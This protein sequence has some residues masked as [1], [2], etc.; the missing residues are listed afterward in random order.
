MAIDFEEQEIFDLLLEQGAEPNARAS[1][2]AAGFG[3]HT[4][5]FNAVVNCGWVQPD[6]V[7]FCA[8]TPGQGGLSA[9]SRDR[10]QILGLL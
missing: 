1:I 2:D 5:L 10:A 9:H 4:P 6:A 7:R 3:G 8:N